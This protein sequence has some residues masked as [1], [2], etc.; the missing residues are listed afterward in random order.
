MSGTANTGLL[1]PLLFL[2]FMSEVAAM[3]HEFRERGSGIR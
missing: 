2:K 1:V 3:V